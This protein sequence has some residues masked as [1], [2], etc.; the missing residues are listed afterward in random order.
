MPRI[1]PDVHD[2]TL[3]ELYTE[4]AFPPPATDRPYVYLDMVASVDG[5]AT[6][7]GRTGPL[8]GE[9]DRV[10]FSRLREWCDVIL[11]GASTVRIEDYGPPRPSDAARMRRRS[12]GLGPVPRLVVVT[13]TLSLNPAARLFADPARQPLVLV[14]EDAD[15]ARR[16]A[17]AEVAEVSGVG[18]G[19]VDLVAALRALRASGVRYVLCEGGPTLNGELLA[20]G[21]V[22]E[23]FLTI[24]PRLVGSSAYRIVQG[25]LPG[26]PQPI[27]LREVREH[28]GELL[29]R[30]GLTPGR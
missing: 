24:S 19:R 6:A 28:G 1:H 23:L 18:H 30:Y 7:Q 14:P 3:D 12:R 26:A 29:L 11:V 4:L 21:L 20:A 13:A 2:E 27:E 8:G 17:L 10:A 5:A 9:A 22:D 25:P 16:A 15:P